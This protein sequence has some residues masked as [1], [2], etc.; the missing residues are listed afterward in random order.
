MKALTYDTP[1]N[2]AE[3]LVERIAVT[4]KLEICLEYSGTFGITCTLD[5]RHAL[6]SVDE[7]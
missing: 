3:E 2:N 6:K 1:A 4:G 7:T 5:V